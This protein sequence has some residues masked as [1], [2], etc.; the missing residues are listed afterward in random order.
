MIITMI[1][2][3]IEIAA[4]VRFHFP[5]D[6]LLMNAA[7]QLPLFS[8]LFSIKCRQTVKNI[9]FKGSNIKLRHCSQLNMLIEKCGKEGFNLVI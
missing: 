9:H 4:V 6:Y 1:K 2:M 8:F 7:F 3:M 5:K